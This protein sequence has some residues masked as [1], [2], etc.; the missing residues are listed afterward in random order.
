MSNEKVSV[1]KFATGFV[2]PV[3]WW[4]A[5]SVA[6]KIGL[7][8]LLCYMVYATFIQKKQT[9][10][11]SITVEKGGKA[12]IQQRQARK[13]FIIPFIEVG[14][15]QRQDDNLGTYIRGGVRFEF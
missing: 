5:A 3:E 7:G 14:V 10:T 1:K 13:R 6:I 15:E 8:L 9:Q 4:K 2:Q 11:Q 12:I